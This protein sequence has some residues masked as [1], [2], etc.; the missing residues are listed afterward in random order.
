MLPF[1][2]AV[3]FNTPLPTVKFK[4]TKRWSISNAWVGEPALTNTAE[5]MLA[6]LGV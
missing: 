1:G 2:G 4:P 3:A 5:D 6:A